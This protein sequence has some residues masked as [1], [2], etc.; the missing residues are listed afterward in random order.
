M[1]VE[2]EPMVSRNRAERAASIS[3]L[4]TLNRVQNENSAMDSVPNFIPGLHKCGRPIFSKHLCSFRITVIQ[5]FKFVVYRNIFYSLIGGWLCAPQISHN[6]EITFN[7]LKD[8]NKKFAELSA[9]HQEGKKVKFS[10][11]NISNE[12]ANIPRNNFI[13]WSK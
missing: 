5:V 4:N 7:D 3:N 11:N 10:V 12:S 13:H 2:A 6:L 8:F 1:R 9:L